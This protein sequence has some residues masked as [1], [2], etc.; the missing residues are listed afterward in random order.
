M[1]GSAEYTGCKRCGDKTHTVR[2][3][4]L[5]KAEKDAKAKLLAAEVAAANPNK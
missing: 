3:C 2:D 1:P 5:V 4:P